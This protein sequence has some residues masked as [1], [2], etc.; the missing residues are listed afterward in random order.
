MTLLQP[1][2]RTSSPLR[3][4]D[5][6]AASALS[7]AVAL[8]IA[9]GVVD[10]LLQ[11]TLP[12]PWANLANS[13]AVWAVAAFA[14]ARV[15]APTAAVGAAAGAVFLV[16]AVEAYYVAAIAVDLASPSSLVAA[17]SLA[18]AFFGVVA[19]VGFGVAGVWSRAGDTWPA[20]AGLGL[21]SAV[22]VAEAWLRLDTPGT[23]VLTGTAGVLVLASTVHRPV[24][25]RRAALCAGALVV[26]C[27]LAF[28]VAGFGG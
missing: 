25:L 3:A 7:L 24:L 27:H 5:R 13:S 26:P 4:D 11:T 18:W 8:G 1:G 17:S 2:P 6:S 10:L 14:L 23:A 9:L 22:L 19:G 20:A 21:A 16:V 28:G 12:Y 15:L